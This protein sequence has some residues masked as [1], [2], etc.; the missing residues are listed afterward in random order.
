MPMLRPN[1]VLVPQA[2]ASMVSYL[3]RENPGM[4]SSTSTLVRIRTLDTHGLACIIFL[5]VSASVAETVLDSP[6]TLNLCGSNTINHQSCPRHSKMHRGRLCV[7]GPNAAGY[8][9]DS[10]AVTIKSLW[11]QS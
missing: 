3:S 4:A 1:W 9:A 11:G 10:G 2:V 8:I 5:L 6:L 7:F